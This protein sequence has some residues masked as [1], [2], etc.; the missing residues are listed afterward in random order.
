MIS[1]LDVQFVFLAPFV[2]HIGHFFLS[3]GQFSLHADIREYT[4]VAYQ[5][6]PPTV[7]MIVFWVEVER[8]TMAR[9]NCPELSVLAPFPPAVP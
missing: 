4:G 2:P 8:L 6:A 1:D 5:T 9:T 3:D 7:M